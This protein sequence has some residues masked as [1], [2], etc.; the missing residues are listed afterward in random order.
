MN[1]AKYS[2]GSYIAED[3]LDLSSRS[4][5]IMMRGLDLQHFF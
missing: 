5:N 1:N 2:V 4:Y 3:D